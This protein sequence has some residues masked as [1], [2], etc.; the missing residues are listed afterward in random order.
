[1]SQC[2]MNKKLHC[3]LSI[4]NLKTSLCE[5]ALIWSLH[6]GSEGMCSYRM[7]PSGSASLVEGGAQKSPA[8]LL[9]LD[10]DDAKKMQGP[11]PCAGKGQALL[12]AAWPWSS[13][14]MDQ[15]AA[16]RTLVHLSAVQHKNTNLLLL[17]CTPVFLL[18]VNCQH[19]PA[20]CCR[21]WIR[22]LSVYWQCWG[23]TDVLLA[24]MAEIWSE[25]PRGW[26]D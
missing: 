23:V 19:H 24:V 16:E 4:L 20:S 5:A 6:E 7:C 17:R 11:S 13:E 8:Q 22:F 14:N 1:M 9:E 12:N 2:D 21:G 26:G 3:S 15:L 18:S 10:K 25:Q